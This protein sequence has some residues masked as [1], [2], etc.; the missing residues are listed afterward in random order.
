MGPLERTIAWQLSGD[1]KAPYETRID[2]Q[3]WRIR[4]N[5]FP[6][7]PHLYTLLIDEL[8]VEQFTD[9]PACWN[10]PRLP[11]TEGGEPS[12]PER[13]FDP[14]QKDEYDEAAEKFERTKRIKPS[15]LV[16]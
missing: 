5:D 15:K 9:W 6:R 4:V 1:R 7:V 2:G 8:E 16:K 13:P 11:G 12:I 14:N 10:R 3:H